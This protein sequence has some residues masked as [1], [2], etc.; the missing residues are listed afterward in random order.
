MTQ[1]AE[2]WS[3]LMCNCC[4]SHV[5]YSLFALSS[6]IFQFQA[7]PRISL[8]VQHWGSGRDSC[9][10]LPRDC[11]QEG[12][13]D[14]IPVREPDTATIQGQLWL[15]A[16]TCLPAFW[17]MCSGSLWR[18]HHLKIKGGKEPSRGSIWITDSLPSAA[19]HTYV[20][21]SN[22]FFFWKCVRRN[23][24]KFTGIAMNPC[25]LSAAQ[26][27]TRLRLLSNANSF[28]RLIFLKS[29]ALR[30]IKLW[31]TEPERQVWS[32][33]RAKEVWL[34]TIGRKNLL[35]KLTLKR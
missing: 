25:S 28:S 20:C 11:L 33:A 30:W 4:C 10:H 3:S 27:S 29:A 18:L 12:N 22:I 14:H 5:F 21:I 16:A 9:S 24:C 8:N 1:K 32:V 35:K 7:V 2:I 34:N 17:W 13:I 26:K 23:L 19:S 31:L 6:N 15:H